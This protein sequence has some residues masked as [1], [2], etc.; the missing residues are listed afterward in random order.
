MRFAL[1]LGRADPAKNVHSLVEAFSDYHRYRPG[2]E[3]RLVLA[4][5]G[6]ADV[7]SCEGVLSMG[8]VDDDL[9]HGLLESCVALVQP[10]VSES[11]SRAVME[12]WSYGKPVAVNGNCPATKAAVLQCN[13][14][15]VASSTHD[16]IEVF[17]AVDRF[18]AAVLHNLGERGRMYYRGNGTPA[19][20]LERYRA[21]LDLEPP[22]GA[23]PITARG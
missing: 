4:G 2:S 8:D 9:K 1:Y 10:S 18:P 17:G 12:A 22:A 6:T 14:G 3:L 5:S 23:L 15:W 7:P 11:F 13:G 16:W 19:R 21:A 20:V